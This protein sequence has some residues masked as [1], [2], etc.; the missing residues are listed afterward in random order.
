MSF[1]T[2]RGRALLI[3]TAAVAVLAG[4]VAAQTGAFTDSRDGKKYKTG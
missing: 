3:A 2:K 4:T 1:I